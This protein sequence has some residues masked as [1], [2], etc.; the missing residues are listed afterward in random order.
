MPDRRKLPL[1]RWEPFFLAVIL[2]AALAASLTLRAGTVGAIV[3][4]LAA[5]VAVPAVIQLVRL[6]LREG[7]G[8]NSARRLV[9]ID[10]FEVTVPATSG[11]VL[12]DETK[13]RQDSI[14]LALGWSKDASAVAVLWPEATRW[15]G[16]E[17]RTEV[18]LI[19]GG[20]PCRAGFLPRAVDEAVSPG[21]V[22]LRERGML[23]SVAAVV[24]G[25]GRRADPDRPFT[26]LARP[27]TVEIAVPDEDALR[28]ISR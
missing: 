20:R 1:L 8:R 23:V 25:N 15:L 3:G 26:R 17:L 6:G 5:V 18:Y 16:R 27:F 7:E 24:I 11:R 13:T 19:N 22:E 28:E 21:L 9:S 4:V 2:L 14:D 12:L 10:G